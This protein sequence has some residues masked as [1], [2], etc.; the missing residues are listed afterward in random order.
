MHHAQGFNVDAGLGLTSCG[1]GQ[2]WLELVSGSRPLPV[3]FIYDY[4]LTFS[5]EIDLF[6]FQ[7]R[8]TW[9]FAFFIA[10]RY[11]GLFSRIPTFF[12]FF[13]PM[14][15]G[16]WWEQ[17]GPGP[18]PS[19]TCVVHRCSDL[20]LFN[21]IA[22]LVLQLIGGMIMI[23]RVYAF[24]N[25]DRRILSLLVAVAMICVGISG[26]ELSFHSP[27]TATSKPTTT[28][29]GTYPKCREL[30]TSAEASHWA[31]AWGSQLVFDALV[32]TLTFRKLIKARSLGKW[33][34]MALS[35]RDGA[36]YFAVMTATN[37]ANIVTYLVMANPYERSMLA[38]PTNMLCAV[39]ISRLMLNL[40]DLEHE[41]TA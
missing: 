9:A 18:H 29:Q 2:C 5:K 8:R 4:A 16:P 7:P 27:S 24:Y 19:L 17:F 31:V 36:L 35:L 1:E 12:L 3:L 26:W 25:Q 10:N 20:Q 13:L 38:S 28:A 21:S 15:G 33:S 30:V 23:A 22:I 34:Y 11:I 32:F 39:M 41:V 37:V 14:A 6:W 40:R